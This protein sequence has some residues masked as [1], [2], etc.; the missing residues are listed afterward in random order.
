MQQLVKVVTITPHSYQN[1]SP[2]EALQPSV[3]ELKVRAG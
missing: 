1:N 3:L 2:G